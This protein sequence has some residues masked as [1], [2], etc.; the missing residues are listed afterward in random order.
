MCVFPGLKYF[1]T[2]F[3]G[4][5]VA[6]SLVICKLTL[7]GIRLPV[8]LYYYLETSFSRQLVIEVLYQTRKVSDHVYMCYGCR[9]W[10]WFWSTFWLIN[11]YWMSV[12]QMRTVVFPVKSDLFFVHVSLP[13]NKMEEKKYHFDVTFTNS[14]RNIAVV[15]VIVWK[16]VLQLPVQSVPI[17]TNIVSSNPTQAGCTRYNIVW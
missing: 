15:G 1:T 4:F 6:Q 10:K 8:D 3:C 7:S 2:G 17:T 14:N 5:C 16:L 12:S 13:I 11:R 9:V